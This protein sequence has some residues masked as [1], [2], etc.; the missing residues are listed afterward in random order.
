VAVPPNRT[1]ALAYVSAF[2]EEAKASGV[3]RKALDGAG[4]NGPVAPAGS[5]P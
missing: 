1:A 3:V 4:I 5:K 2:V